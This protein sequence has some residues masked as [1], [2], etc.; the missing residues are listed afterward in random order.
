MKCPRCDGLGAVSDIPPVLT[1]RLVE[2][3]EHLATGASEREAARRLHV[4]R[5]TVHSHVGRILRYFGVNSTPDAIVKAR[6][7]DVI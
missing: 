6:K 5:S 1:P 4:S 3:L 2:V 7:W